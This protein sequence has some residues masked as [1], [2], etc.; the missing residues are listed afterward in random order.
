M[1]T[2]E[3]L[4]YHLQALYSLYR[5]YLP[6][7]EEARHEGDGDEQ[8]RLLA[9]QH[10]A[11][12]AEMETLEQALNLLSARYKME[13]SAVAAGFKEVT[14]RFRHQMNPSREQ[15]TIYA[16][17]AALS[18]AH[19]AVGKYQGDIE[20][21][22]AVGEQDVAMLLEENLRRQTECQRALRAATPKLIQEL[23]AAEG[24]QAA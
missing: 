23:S 19:L 21:A 20:L 3:Q 18:L 16:L 4:I 5:D 22:R 15:L 10:D 6:Q 14:G 8:A 2:R 12:R 11:I 1:T 9:M 7:L 13:H 17:L 24:Q